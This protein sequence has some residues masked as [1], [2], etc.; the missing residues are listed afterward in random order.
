[1]NTPPA[2]M[3][4]ADFQRLIERLYFEKDSRRGLGGTF[5]WFVE[6]VGELGSALRHVAANPDGPQAATRRAELEEEFAD[7]LAWLNTLASLV[8]VEMDQAVAKYA[9]G[10]PVCRQ[11]PCTC[12]EPKP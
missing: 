12:P 5:M 10:C 1:M 4:L 6:E 3:T 8:G 2:P 11:S 9:D 7:V